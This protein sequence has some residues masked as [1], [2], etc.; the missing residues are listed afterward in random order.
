MSF[1]EKHAL[2][3]LPKKIEAMTAE[4]TALEASLAEN[5]LHARDAQTL[6]RASE[7]YAAKRE[8]L[9]KAEEQWLKLEMLREEIEGAD[10]A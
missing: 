10:P 1:N 4:L 8:E 3:T 2:Q 7:A 5:Q 6:R 9:E